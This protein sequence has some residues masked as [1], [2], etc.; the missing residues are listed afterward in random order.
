MS[1]IDK[2]TSDENIYSAIE[3]I[4]SN[5]G[6]KTPGVDGKTIENILRVILEELIFQKVMAKQDL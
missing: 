6:S 2:I 1:L 3:C 4:K 5:S